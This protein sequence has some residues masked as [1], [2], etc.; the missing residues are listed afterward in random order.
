MHSKKTYLVL[1]IVTG[2]LYAASIVTAIVLIATGVLLNNV[3]WLIITILY[4][5]FFAGLFMRYI[6]RYYN[7]RSLLSS[8][9]LENLYSFGQ[10]SSFF[11][12]YAFEQ[13]VN[14]KRRSFRLIKKDQSIIVFTATPVTAV[15]GSQQAAEVSNLHL[16][17]AY[18]LADLFNA[19]SGLFYRRDFYF[20]FDRGTFIIYAFDKKKKDIDDVVVAIRDRIY[21]ILEKKRYH[22]YVQPFFGIAKANPLEPLLAQIDNASLARESAEHN[23]ESFAYFTD[24][25]KKAVSQSQVEEVIKAFEDGEFVVYYQPKFSLVKK[26]FVSSEALI[27]WN[28]P[29]YGLVMPGKFIDL[30]DAAGLLHN[31]DVYVFKKVCQDLAETKRRGRRLLPVSVNFS[32]YEFYSPEFQAL[33]LDTIKEANIDP[34]LIEIEITETTSQANQFLSVSIIKKLKEAGIRILMDDFGIGYSN[35]GNLRKIPFDAVKIDKSFI[36]GMREDPE[37]GHDIVRM[38]VSMC[39]ASGYETI[40]EGVDSKEEVDFLRRV[41]CSTI[42]GFYYSQAISK[43]DYDRFLL[44]NPFEG[45][46]KA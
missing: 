8:L 31:L 35:I 13:R 44:D 33:I 26:E 10:R 12:L 25:M 34:S 2:A 21:Q 9:R 14:L 22:L 45:G 37:V 23:F 5:A 16:H 15:R 36:D 42:Q 40:A 3:L 29:K 28:S 11:N 19:K 32:L 27:R 7:Q 46:K 20:C 18:A 1:A 17:I 24:A 41:R 4:L 38:I 30:M 6:S 39:N 43:E